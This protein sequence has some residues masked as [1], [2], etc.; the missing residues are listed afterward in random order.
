MHCN[1]V[2]TLFYV[3]LRYIIFLYYVLLF[4]TN[5]LSNLH[6]IIVIYLNN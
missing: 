2:F 1:G 4:A 5:F 6:I 3:R